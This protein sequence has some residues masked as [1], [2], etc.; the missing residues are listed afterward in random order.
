MVWETVKGLGDVSS[1]W[2]VELKQQVDMGCWGQERFSS[3]LVLAKLS[4]SNKSHGEAGTNF[5]QIPVE[6]VWGRGRVG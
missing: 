4:R 3:S 6:W 2:Q 1:L 5:N